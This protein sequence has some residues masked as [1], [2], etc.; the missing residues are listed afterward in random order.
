[1]E[2]TKHMSNSL[3]DY[4]AYAGAG[5]PTS[6][7]A[8]ALAQIAVETISSAPAAASGTVQHGQHTFDYELESKALQQQIDD[9]SRRKFGKGKKKRRV[10]LRLK[11]ELANVMKRAPNPE[12]FKATLSVRACLVQ[13]YLGASDLR[14]LGTAS[15]SFGQSLHQN[16]K[17]DLAFLTKFWE[18]AGNYTTPAAIGLTPHQ[19]PY[20]QIKLVEQYLDTWCYPTDSLEEKL[21]ALPDLVICEFASKMGDDLVAKFIKEQGLESWCLT[22]RSYRFKI[23]APFR[24]RIAKAFKEWTENPESS[25]RKLSELSL[26]YLE[27]RAIPRELGNLSSLQKL[28]LCRSNLTAVPR[29]LGKLSSLQELDLK[30]NW[31]TAVPI[32]LGKLFSLELLNLAGNQLK[33]IPKELGNLTSLKRLVLGFNQLKTV[34]RELGKLIFLR[35]LDLQQNMLIAIPRE[36]GNLSSLESLDLYLNPLSSEEKEFWASLSGITAE[37]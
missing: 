19:A 16:V 26:E 37:L 13:Q 29:E 30:C 8:Q 25:I 27:L 10:I 34:P 2:L 21:K 9:V 12:K 15:T 3:P 33:A 7:P 1:M 22:K 35:A 36:L 32:E 20:E 24:E 17:D 28:L 18:V 4:P 5:V 11:R 14:N 31:L 23:D 6:R